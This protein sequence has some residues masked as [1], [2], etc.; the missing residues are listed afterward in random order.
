[1]IIIYE[2]AEM[3]EI[4]S[5]L[6]I[7]MERTKNL[8]MTDEEKAAF[9]RK[10]MAGKVRGWIQRYRDGLIDL[11]HLKSEF[12]KELSANP[13]LTSILRSQVLDSTKLNEDNSRFLIILRDILAIDTK[14]IESEIES[15]KHELESLRVKRT[16][17]IAEDLKKKKIYGSA[18][19]PNPV[20]DWVLQE[21]LTRAETELRAQLKSLP[22]KD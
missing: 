15:A 16:A 4:K 14:D 18:V 12:A 5:T 7:I 1:M 19:V 22:R 21:I 3:A 17:A 6:D 8:T 10:E 13:D 20:R 2:V 9:R 11:D